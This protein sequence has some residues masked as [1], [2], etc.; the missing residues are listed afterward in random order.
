MT[1][2]VK[3]QASAK[4]RPVTIRFPAGIVERI[5]ELAQKEGRS[6]N[7]EIVKRLADSISQERAEAEAA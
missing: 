1:E 6:R 7:T 5:D 2:I 3:L 4:D